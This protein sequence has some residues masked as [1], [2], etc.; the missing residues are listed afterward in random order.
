MSDVPADSDATAETPA[1]PIA[2]PRE[3]AAAVHRLRGR[4]SDDRPASDLPPDHP[5]SLA[6]QVRRR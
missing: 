1:E 5:T 2:D 6:R 3:L 4:W